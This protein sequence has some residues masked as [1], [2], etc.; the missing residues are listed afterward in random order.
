MSIKNVSYHFNEDLYYM[1][2]T[3]II[4]LFTFRY[5]V[6]VRISSRSARILF[7]SCSKAKNPHRFRTD[8]KKVGN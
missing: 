4:A 7:E 8:L 5:N 1:F 6:N 3:K 2:A